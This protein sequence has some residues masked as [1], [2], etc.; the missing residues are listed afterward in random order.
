MYEA[1]IQ[2]VQHNCLAKREMKFFF[3]TKSNDLTLKK[4]RFL[5]FCS[6]VKNILSLSSINE[7]GI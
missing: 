3:I 2:K 6:F 4:K 5:M 7:N 1:S